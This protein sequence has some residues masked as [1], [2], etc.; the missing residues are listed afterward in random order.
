MPR[1][2][3]NKGLN[4]QKLHALLAEAQKKEEI[5]QKIQHL[6]KWKLFGLV[7]NEKQ[8]FSVWSRGINSNSLPIKIEAARIQ[9]HIECKIGECCRDSSKFETGGNPGMMYN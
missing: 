4:I 6:R 9:S 7:K 5:K 1:K 8:S 2:L 3:E